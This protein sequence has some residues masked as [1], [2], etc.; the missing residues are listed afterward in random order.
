[1]EARVPSPWLQGRTH[2]PCHAVHVGLQGEGLGGSGGIAQPRIV[3]ELVF[4]VQVQVP[5][6]PRIELFDEVA[7]VYARRGGEGQS[8]LPSRQVL[9]HSVLEVPDT[10]GVLV[11]E[12][13]TGQ[14]GRGGRG[15]AG[16]RWGSGVAGGGPHSRM[17]GR[18]RC[19]E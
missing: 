7:G 13:G 17:G 5:G 10:V 14:L 16:L 4:C 3:E 11:G 8:A 15:R 18:H 9:R 2:G 19:L 6:L 12:G 1:M